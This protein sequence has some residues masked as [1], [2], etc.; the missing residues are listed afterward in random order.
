MN[1]NQQIEIDEY[2]VVLKKLPTKAVLA[3][4]RFSFYDLEDD[5][6]KMSRLLNS[7]VYKELSM[8]EHVPNG[9]EKIAIRKERGKQRRNNGSKRKHK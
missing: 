5:D 3:Q 6:L 2:K 7:L 1:T 8:R 4:R 9:E